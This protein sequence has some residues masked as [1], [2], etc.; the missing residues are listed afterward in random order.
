VRDRIKV[1]HFQRKPRP[2]FN[3]SIESIFEN[4][5]CRLTD[6]IDFSI[7]ICGR[8]N[9]GYFTK[10]WNVV[11][12]AFRQ[13]KNAI[14][15]I[16]G[17][18]HFIDLLMRKKN[19]LLTIHD[20]RFMQRKKGIEK[21]IMG[22]LY[23]TA[24][25]N[26]SAYVTTVSE[27]TKQEVIAY[28]TC[29]PGKITVIPV[30]VSPVFKPAPQ[31][32]NKNCPVILQIG[33]ADNKNLSRLIEAIKDIPCRLVIVGNPK[34]HDLEKLDAC[35]IDFIIKHDLSREE[36]YQEYVN[37][38]IVSFASTFEGFGMPIIEANSVERVVITSNISS[39]PEVAGNAACLVDPYAADDIRMGLLRIINDDTYREQLIS[40]GRANRKRF[41]GET[42]ADAYYKLYKKMSLEITR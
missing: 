16:T 15:H 17:E 6:K 38:D 21:K 13:E 5:R 41:S 42:V 7:K 29:N 39:M 10:F 2:G 35:R 32:F 37:C 26:R 23:L 19:V 31:V 27:A 28:T 4:I 12:A 8:F 40:N 11:E 20:C 30:S 34:K 1:I 14:A 9:D 3:F 25:V 24:P 33:A 36:L 18:V 22:W